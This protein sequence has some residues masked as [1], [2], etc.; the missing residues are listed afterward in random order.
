MKLVA[1]VVFLVSDPLFVTILGP[2]GVTFGSTWHTG[3]KEIVNTSR[4]PWQLSVR[5]SHRG[6]IGSEVPVAVISQSQGVTLVGV[7]STS[8]LEALLTCSV[9]PSH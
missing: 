5:A 6:P 3:A 7:G 8:S 2:A 1:T 9:V 4:E